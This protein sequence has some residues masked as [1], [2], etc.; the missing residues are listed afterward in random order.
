MLS[1]PT[2]DANSSFEVL[3]AAVEERA[4]DISQQRPPISFMH[5]DRD[6]S[7]PARAAMRAAREG[8]K[9]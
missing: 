2:D 6:V 5:P 3:G 7:R 8:S 4:K 1:W 9:L